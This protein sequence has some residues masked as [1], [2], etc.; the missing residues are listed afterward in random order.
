MSLKILE[1]SQR[2][3]DIGDKHNP[4]RSLLV[5]D[6][7]HSNREQ[8]ETSGWPVANRTRCGLDR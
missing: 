2:I 4:G 1:L 7:D 5:K 6:Q 3:Y 8:L